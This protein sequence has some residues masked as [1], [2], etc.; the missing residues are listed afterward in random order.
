[1]RRARHGSDGPVSLEVASLVPFHMTAYAHFGKRPNRYKSDDLIM[2]GNFV[3]KVAFVTG[4]ANGIG[5]ATA[6]AFA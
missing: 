6:L 1:M 4:A 5:R 2:S 3:E